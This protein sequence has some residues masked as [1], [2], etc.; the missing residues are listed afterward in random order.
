M[1]PELWMNKT[2]TFGRKPSIITAIHAEKEWV[3]PHRRTEKRFKAGRPHGTDGRK[4][5]LEWVWRQ[6]RFPSRTP[7]DKKGCFPWNNWIWVAPRKW[8]SSLSSQST[9]MLIETGAFFVSVESGVRSGE[10]RGR[11]VLFFTDRVC[12][13]VPS[14]FF[15]FYHLEAV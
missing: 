15:C 14:T 4:T 3:R 8:F 9:L 2:L 13:A 7:K 12:L 6:A 11:T 5:S 1:N 10:S